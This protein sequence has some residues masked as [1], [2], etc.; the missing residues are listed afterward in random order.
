MFKRRA[1]GPRIL[2]SEPAAPSMA[3][4]PAPMTTSDSI[5]A[6]LAYLHHVGDEVREDSRT[7]SNC[8]RSYIPTSWVSAPWAT[9]SGD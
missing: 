5:S 4:A 3:P 2:T 1:I 9:C 8:H 7:E 6:D